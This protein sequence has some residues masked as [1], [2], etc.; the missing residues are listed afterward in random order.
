MIS[1]KIEK[2]LNDQMNFENES[3]F[4]YLAMSNFLRRSNLDGASKWMLHQ[5][6]EE[7]GHAR[8][9][10]DYLHENGCDVHIDGFK[11]PTNT[12]KDIEEVLNTALKHE[13]LVTS[14]FV[15]IMDQAKS[16][17]DYAT[18][19]FIQWFILEQVEEEDNVQ[20]L[21]DRFKLYPKAH[22]LLFDK[23]M[24]QRTE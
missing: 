7:Q 1:K 3:A 8:K 20:D 4:I 23:D 21:I 2:L 6:K 9:I 11:N 19:S 16:E 22:L 14:K 18:E 15:K 24:G 10:Y 17:K 13:Q 12:Y 5:Y